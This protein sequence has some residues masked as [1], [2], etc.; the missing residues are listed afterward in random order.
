VPRF[1]AHFSALG[2]LV[3]DE[4]HDLIRTCYSELQDA[5]FPRLKPIAEEMSAE[6][7][8]ML[9]PGIEA[10][11]QIQLDLRYIGQEFT[12]PVPVP[13]EQ[14]ATSDRLAV[15]KA[16]DL[17]HEQRYAHHAP[18]E[19]VEII[20]IRIVARGKRPKLSLPPLAKGSS[21]AA[22]ERR[23]VYFDEDNGSIEC[24]VYR[25]EEMPPGAEC[26][27]PALVSEYGS[28][29]VIFPGD[30]LS[31]ADTGEL[32]IAVKQEYAATAS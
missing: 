31:V 28:T 6:A 8:R 4:R 32:I 25:R 9:T 11:Y 26:A 2:M 23:S 19:P 17:L 3:A 16:F 1:P 12:L 27:G 21:I 14:L 10:T 22:R 24:P 30:R 18:D 20:N 7:R 29:T 13:A 5:D 15:R